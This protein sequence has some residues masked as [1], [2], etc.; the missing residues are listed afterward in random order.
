MGSHQERWLVDRASSLEA[1][2]VSA[3]S[4][5]SEPGVTGMLLHSDDA[6]VA[7]LDSAQLVYSVTR[8]EPVRNGEFLIESGAATSVCQQSL[9]DSLGG[10]P[11]GPGIELRSATGHQFTTTGTRRSACT[12]ETVSTCRATFRSIPRIRDCSD[13]FS[14]LD[15]CETSSRFATLV[16]RYSASSQATESSLS[17]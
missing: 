1:S 12:R 14:Q 15:K 16:E 7:M 17:V 13:L 4:T 5:T 10:K 2:T 6:E 3:A 9:A 8:Q 11:N